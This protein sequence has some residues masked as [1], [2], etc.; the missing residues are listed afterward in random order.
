MMT[1][2]CFAD[3]ESVAFAGL[4]SNRLYHL[5][6]CSLRDEHDDYRILNE[7]H[8]GRPTTPNGLLP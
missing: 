3:R 6:I 7:D 5:A 4:A 2:A 8:L 1:W